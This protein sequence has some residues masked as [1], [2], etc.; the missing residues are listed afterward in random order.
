[1]WMGITKSNQPEPNRCSLSIFLWGLSTILWTLTM[2]Q[3]PATADPSADPYFE[4]ISLRPGVRAILVSRLGSR[5]VAL[6][7]V[8]HLDAADLGIEKAGWLNLMGDLLLKG[9][10]TKT[11][12]EISREMAVT[13]GE[14]GASAG[15][16][17]L[18]LG[19]TVPAA[20]VAT[21]WPLIVDTVLN[22]RFSEEDFEKEK[23]LAI[24]QLVQNRDRPSWELHRH[25][26]AA[27]FPDHPYGIHALGSEESLTYLDFESMQAFHRDV[28]NRSPLTLL[29]VGKLDLADWEKMIAPFE[30]WEVNGGDPSTPDPARVPEPSRVQADA[31]LVEP[32]LWIGRRFKVESDE[33]R[34]TLS[35]L[36]A[37][38]ES[39]QGQLF[40]GVREE[41]AQVYFIRTMRLERRDAGIW[42]VQ[43][44]T[45]RRNLKRVERL[46]RDELKRLVEEGISEKDLRIAKKKL[47]TQL[48]INAETNSPIAG[49]LTYRLLQGLEPLSIGQRKQL[50]EAVTVA[51][52]QQL[53][54]KL[55]T[56]DAFTTITVS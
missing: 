27:L 54:Q 16:E 10:E 3:S 55:L 38:L 30:Q 8:W 17:G 26:L 2:P 14:L 41:A 50:V 36:E 35:V 29:A 40:A 18:L 48:T 22:A 9:T 7:V 4:E 42:G 15:H 32:H 13:G 5:T 1:M 52:I 21:A 53:A 31:K 33:E 44:A 24:S 11:Q 37:H 6:R 47:L 46:T 25:I 45:A 12:V 28:L 34:Y 19:A 49:F 56:L 23:T 51:D 20:E 39:W 43:T